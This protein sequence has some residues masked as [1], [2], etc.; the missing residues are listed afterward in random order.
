MIYV[1]DEKGGLASHPVRLGITD[2]TWTEV[3]GERPV[4]GTAIVTGTQTAAEKASAS[5]AGKT[6]PFMPGRPRG[7]SGPPPHPM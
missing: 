3:L 2:G 4:E 7:V 5:G 1:L 6:S